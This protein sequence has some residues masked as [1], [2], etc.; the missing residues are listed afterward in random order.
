M[1]MLHM[2][3]HVKSD[4]I[5]CPYFGCI[6]IFLVLDSTITKINKFIFRYQ[7]SCLKW[8][9]QEHRSIGVL[10]IVKHPICCGYQVLS[11]CTIRILFYILQIEEII[12]FKELLVS[13]LA[14]V[15]D[16]T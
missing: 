3:P 1:V 14:V 11:T 10:Q 7:S 4:L 12:D 16:Q 5:L 9:R 8:P 6:L 13:I 15:T 2:A